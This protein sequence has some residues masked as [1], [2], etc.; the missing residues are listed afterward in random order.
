MHTFFLVCNFLFLEVI[1]IKTL[2]LFSG[3]LD[4]TTALVYAIKK[5]GNENVTA[6]SITYGQKHSKE[7]KQ[8]KEI[9]KHYNIVLR[10]I[11]LSEMFKDSN[12]SLLSHSTDEILD[13]N[14]KEQIKDDTPASTYVPFRNGL[15]LSVAASIALS[16]NA[17]II[18]Y[19]I[20]KDD[21]VLNAY[22]DTS[23]EFNKAISDAIYLGSGK[24]VVVEGLFVDKTKSDI[25]KLGLELDVKYE[26]TTSC[27]HGRE[28]ACGLCATC[29]DRL[30][31]FSENNATDPVEYEVI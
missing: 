13:G 21:N 1:I 14:Y 27:Y 31:A 4:S 2:V 9:A 17:D 11:D 20:H 15:F 6:L 19:A 22:P 29:I 8:A 26:L 12:C 23:V 24:Q 3:G 7:V 10:V 5:Y 16:I 25:V 28:K 30:K 18:Y